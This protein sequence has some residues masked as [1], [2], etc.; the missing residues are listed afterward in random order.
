MNLNIIKEKYFVPEN[1]LDIGANVGQFYKLCQS[2]FSESKILSIEGNI[3]CKPH[4]LKVNPNSI[5]CLLDSEPRYRDFFLNRDCLLSTGSSVYLELTKHFEYD[6]AISVS[7]KTN[8]LDNILPYQVFDLIKLDTQGSEIDILK[9]GK[10][11]M[12]R[13]K[14]CIVEVS[15]QPYN[16]DAPLSYE[17]VDYMLN[18]NFALR[19]TLD[20]NKKTSQ[21][22]FFFVN[23]WWEYYDKFM[24]E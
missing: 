14:G 15:H 2:V 24:Q 3:L 21:S 5:F 23:K 16:L 20:T 22:D 18:N 4:L 7:V 1:I 6:K 9:G 13:A 12:Q 17:V 19:K 11:L 10:R 8:T